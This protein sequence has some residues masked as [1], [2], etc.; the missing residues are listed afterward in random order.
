MPLTPFPSPLPLLAHSSLLCGLTLFST[1]SSSRSSNSSSHTMYLT[2]TTLP[3]PPPLSP[4]P[5]PP[6][7]QRG[8][9]GTW[10]CLSAM[11]RPCG[12]G[13]VFTHTI[14]ALLCPCLCSRT[15]TSKRATGAQARAHAPETSLPVPVLRARAIAIVRV[16]VHLCGHAAP[17]KRLHPATN[18]RDETQKLTLLHYTRTS[19]LPL[20]LLLPA[21]FLLPPLP[22]TS[23]SRTHGV[24]SCASLRVSTT[25]PCA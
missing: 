23:S 25:P 16:R 12:R 22:L 10:R 2:S 9:A 8:K 11:G 18:A 15:N 14:F 20:P 7:R 17:V 24:C 1:A 4:P 13:F 6:R 21:L 3:L 5:R 19:P